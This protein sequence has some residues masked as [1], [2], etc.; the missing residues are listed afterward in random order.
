MSG[1]PAAVSARQPSTAGTTASAELAG[2]YVISDTYTVPGRCRRQVGVLRRFIIFSALRCSFWHANDA[3]IQGRM[4]LFARYT[5]AG[6]DRRGW[7]LHD[8]GSFTALFA[9]YDP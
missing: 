9:G 2:V 1:C 8:P 3:P 5:R 7:L 4:P 6:A